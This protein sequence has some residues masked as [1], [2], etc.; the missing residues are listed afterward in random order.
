MNTT[1]KAFQNK[2]LRTPALI[3]SYIDG[4]IGIGWKKFSN[5]L[6]CTIAGLLVTLVENSFGLQALCFPCR[7]IRHIFFNQ[8]LHEVACVRMEL[9]LI[10]LNVTA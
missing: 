2:R 4:Y 9:L 6:Y 5:F 3:H 1:V 7:I 10:G 8:D